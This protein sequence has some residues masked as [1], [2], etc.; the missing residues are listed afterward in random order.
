MPPGLVPDGSL[1]GDPGDVL[2]LPGVVPPA[3][4]MSW[5]DWPGNPVPL[6]LLA[7]RAGAAP[8]SVNPARSPAITIARICG[9][10]LAAIGGQ[11]PPVRTTCGSEQRFTAPRVPATPGA[12][13]PGAPPAARIWSPMTQRS[14]IVTG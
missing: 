14:L 11:T 13:T 8:M 3:A 4:V 5:H 9:P 1:N 6:G 7:A 2:A 10:P 12:A